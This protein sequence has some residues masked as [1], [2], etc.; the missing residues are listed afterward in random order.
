MRK[1]ASENSIA[2]LRAVAEGKSLA[3]AGRLVSRSSTTARQLLSEA[4]R[5]ISLPS[6]ISEIRK[7]KAN[8]LEKI[9][10]L[11]VIPVLDLNHKIANNLSD[12]LRISLKDITP[13]YTSNISASQLAQHGLTF[14]AISEVQIWLKK[15]G[16]SLKKKV[17]QTNNETVA[18]TRAVA[19]LDAFHFDVRLVQQQLAN[20]ESS[21]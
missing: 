3:E 6:E 7:H 13:K 9:N 8:Y 17:P 1:L 20:L 21:D 12:V 16:L 11:P 5:A 4:C 19:L 10:R 14:T 15:H 2:V 18:V